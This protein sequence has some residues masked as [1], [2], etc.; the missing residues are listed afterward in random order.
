MAPPDAHTLP[1][2][3]CHGS[4]VVV[5]VAVDKVADVVAD[6]AADAAANAVAGKQILACGAVLESMCGL[7][8]QER[9][10]LL[11]AWQPWQLASCVLAQSPADEWCRC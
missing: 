11:R 2:P 4:R 1:Q 3:S 9:H 6:V 10:L 7:A 8:E 5:D